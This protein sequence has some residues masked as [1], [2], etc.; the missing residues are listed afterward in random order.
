VREAPRRHRRH[1][2]GTAPLSVH[3]API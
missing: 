3:L 2:L 1:Q